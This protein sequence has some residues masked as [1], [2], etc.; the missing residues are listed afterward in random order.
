MRILDTSS[1]RASPPSAAPNWL[2]AA[3][4]SH[5]DLLRC[6]RPGVG[7]GDLHLQVHDVLRV[8]RRLYP[9]FVLIAQLAVDLVQIRREIHWIAKALVEEISSHRCAQLG[10]I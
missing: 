3:A 10:Q 9:Q 2:L 5:K 6:L 1:N 4:R 8:C 7:R